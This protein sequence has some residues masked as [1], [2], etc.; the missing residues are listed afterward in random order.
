MRRQGVR[1]DVAKAEV[2]KK[3]LHKL[4]TSIL[5]SIVKEYGVAAD[6]W[7][8]A[9]IAKVFDVAGLKYEFTEKT[10]APSFTKGFLANHPHKLPQMIVKA[11]EYNKAS[12]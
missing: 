8:A 3:S 9:S 10:G 11:R 12:F 2:L 1:V 4:E 6:L 7:A 5:D